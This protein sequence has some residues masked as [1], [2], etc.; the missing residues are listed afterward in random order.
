MIRP[1]PNDFVEQLEWVR[2]YAALRFER[3]DEIRVQR[4]RISRTWQRSVC[5]TRSHA[6]DA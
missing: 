5:C 6:E 2:N 1:E 4:S 3:S